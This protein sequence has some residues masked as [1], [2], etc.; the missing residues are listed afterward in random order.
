MIDLPYVYEGFKMPSTQPV[1]PGKAADYV[2]VYTLNRWITILVAIPDM[3]ARMRMIATQGRQ[4]LQANED[5]TEN[6]H[7][8]FKCAIPDELQTALILPGLQDRFFTMSFRGIPSEKGRYGYN[9]CIREVQILEII[10]IKE[11]R[12]PLYER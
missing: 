9:P 5:R 3:P 10:D 7:P 6:W 12:I 1:T 2:G 8:V 4:P 11:G